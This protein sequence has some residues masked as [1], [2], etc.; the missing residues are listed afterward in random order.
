MMINHVSALG[1]FIL[2]VVAAA[3]F[4]QNRKGK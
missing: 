3:V 2:L 4:S 1:V